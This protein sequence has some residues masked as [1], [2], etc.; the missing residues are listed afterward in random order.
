[1]SENP[2]PAA[3]EAEKLYP[4]IQ[5]MSW[6]YL[7]CIT[8]PPTCCDIWMKWM[9]VLAHEL[10]PPSSHRLKRGVISSTK[11]PNDSPDRRTLFSDPLREIVE[12]CCT[13]RHTRAWHSRHDGCGTGCWHS[14]VCLYN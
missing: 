11:H 3:W 7:V 9:C 5:Q 4:H 12:R 13:W 2:S 10:Y 1:M 6:A 14:I 8:I